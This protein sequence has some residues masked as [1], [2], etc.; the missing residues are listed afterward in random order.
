MSE[1]IDRDVLRLLILYI[2]L[3]YRRI[4]RYQL[5]K[6]TGIS[7]GIIRKIL[8]EFASKNIVDSK[9][10]GASITKTGLAFYEKMLNKYKI[11]KIFSVEIGEIVGNYVSIAMVTDLIENVNVIEVRD[12]TVRWGSLGALILT[13]KNGIL[14]LPP[15]HK[16]IDKIYPKFSRYIKS[17]LG[18]INRATI[19]IAYSSNIGDAFIGAFKGIQYINEIKN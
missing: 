1:V 2:L 13:Y 7:K 4:G 14:A 5:S 8:E 9:R 17:K 11:Y 18:L 16:D 6:Y 10:G 12:E 15:I 19:V 3:N